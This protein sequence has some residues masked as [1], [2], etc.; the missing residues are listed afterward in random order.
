MVAELNNSSG[1]RT[2]S[3]P[4]IKMFFFLFWD[5]Q[6]YPEVKAAL[7]NLSDDLQFVSLSLLAKSGP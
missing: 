7:S 5:F 2:F 6:E 1:L 4:A 3:L